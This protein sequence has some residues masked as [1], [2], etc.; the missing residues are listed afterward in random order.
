MDKAGIVAFLIGIVFCALGGYAI[1]VFL[2][3]VIAVIKGLAGIAVL[4]AGLMLV[5]FGVLIIRE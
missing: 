1:W 5:V 3:D 4:L 2:P